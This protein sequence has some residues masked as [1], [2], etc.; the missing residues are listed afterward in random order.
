[1]LRPALLMPNQTFSVLYE[2]NHLLVVNKPAGML[3]HTVNYYNAHA[4]K[5]EDPVFHKSAEWL[6]PLEGPLAALDCTL[7]RGA[8]W[9]CF[10][11]GGLDTQPS[12]EVLTAKIGR[13]RLI[14]FD[15][16][17]AAIAKR[18]KAGPVDAEL[19]AEMAARRKRVAA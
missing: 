10:T 9:P 13:R 5:G 11:L 6:K 12:G 2:D 1:M 16:L 3:V 8:F 4:A 17:R 19:S 7:G 18:M 14:D 15:S